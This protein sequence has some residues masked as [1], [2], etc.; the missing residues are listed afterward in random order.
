MPRTIPII[1][2]PPRRRQRPRAFRPS[3]NYR[4]VSLSWNA[5]LLAT[6]YSV[7]RSA[8]SGGPYAPIANVDTRANFTDTGLTNG[9]TYYYIVTATNQAGESLP[10]A[11]VSGTPYLSPPGGLA[12]VGRI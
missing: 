10:T 11:E 9:V 6:G 4:Q 1:R 3:A 8:Q 2:H 7:S 12:A 5:S